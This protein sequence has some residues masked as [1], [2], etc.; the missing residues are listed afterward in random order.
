MFSPRL[1]ISYTEGL[2]IVST[3]TLVGVILLILSGMIGIMT[4]KGLAH[5]WPKTLYQ[6]TYLADDEEVPKQIFASLLSRDFVTT[7]GQ[8]RWLF[9]QASLFQFS[10]QQHLIE[11]QQIIKMEP[12]ED[13]TDIQLRNGNRVIARLQG[14]VEGSRPLPMAA[15]D[16]LTE[17]VEGQ[18]EE[19]QALKRGK[20]AAIHMQLAEYD[21]RQVSADAPAR[22]RLVEEFEA[23]SQTLAVAELELSRY[24]LQLLFDDGRYHELALAEIESLHRLNSLTSWQKGEHFVQSLWVFVSEKP[25]RANSAGGVF[26]ALFGTVVMVLMMTLIVTPLGVMAAIYLN[27][28]APENGLTSLLRV[29]VNN[30]A[31]V[32]SIVYG[33]FGLGFFVYQVGGNIDKLFFSEH[34]PAPTFGAP[35]IFWA[36]L[37]MAML[38]LPVVIVATEEGLRRVP[39]SLRQG[40]YALGATQFETV[41]RTVIP[42]A[43]PGIMTG[44]ILAIARGAG[45]VAPLLLVGAVKFAPSLPLDTE[46][47]YL[48]LDRQFMHLGVLIYD[49]AFHSNNIGHGSSMMFASCLLL[50]LVVLILNIVAVW[51]RARLRN[52]YQALA[53]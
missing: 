48:H 2:P 34:L 17:K 31:G 3:A 37:T 38:T 19:L 9:S 12:L 16:K 39:D 24:R 44:V 51:V 18:V 27:E 53:R 46:F 5:F 15:L 50:L 36:S 43:S 26:P 41:W 1:R 42:I 33:V 6:V 4:V 22:Q 21:R 35:G 13:L 23:V 20:L 49:G 25:K 7:E 40:S 28:Y 52:R 11:Q 32:P 30:L 47:P 45:E 14:L 8:K 29:G 10:D